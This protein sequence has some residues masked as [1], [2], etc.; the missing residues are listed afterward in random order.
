VQAYLASFERGFESRCEANVVH[1]IDAVRKPFEGRQQMT[2]LE[3]P[4]YDTSERVVPAVFNPLGEVLMASSY[5]SL[6]MFGR[7]NSP[8]T[9]QPNGSGFF[10]R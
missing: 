10:M 3:R 4:R 1:P 9:V 2:G 6:A 7:R 8:W 5:V